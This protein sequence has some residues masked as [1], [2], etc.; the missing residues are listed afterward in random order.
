M[1]DSRLPI[2]CINDDEINGQFNV[3]E[4]HSCIHWLMDVWMC[5]IR[6]QKLKKKKNQFTA[7][8]VSG[9]QC[10]PL[11]TTHWIKCARRLN[12]W[13]WLWSPNE[14]RLKRT[15]IIFKLCNMRLNKCI[16]AAGW[17]LSYARRLHQFESTII[18]TRIWIDLDAIKSVK[19]ILPF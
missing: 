8:R 7:F 17:L 15:I 11:T 1:V 13:H 16:H 12:G 9:S 18:T 10:R 19:T 14:I 5:D 6:P 4:L 3:N 2:Y